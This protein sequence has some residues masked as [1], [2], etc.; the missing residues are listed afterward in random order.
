MD[1]TNNMN[2]WG[3]SGG[4]VDAPQFKAALANL[5]DGW[6]HVVAPLRAETACTNLGDIR[7]YWA[8]ASKMIG[9]TIILDDIRFVNQA[10]L[11]GAYADRTAAKDATIAIKAIPALDAITV[12]DQA[13]VTAAAE[14]FAAVKDE[15]KPL[16]QNVEAIAAAQAKI[17]ELNTPVVTYT[18][19]GDSF[20][21]DGE[22]VQAYQVIDF[23]GCVYFVSDYNKVA[24]N[25]TL[26]LGEKFI[27]EPGYYT[28]DAQGRAVDFSGVRDGYVFIHNVMQKAYQVVT[29]NGAQYFINDGNKV[30]TNCTLYLTAAFVETPGYYSFDA[31]GKMSAA[32][33]I[34]NG[35]YYEN[36]T[37]ARLYELVEIDGVTYFVN[38]GYFVAKDCVLYLGERFAPGAAGWYTFD[39]TGAMVDYVA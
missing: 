16:V 1:D 6:N 31:E 11:N 36:G 33:G 28:F 20:Y 17:D 10:A 37:V 18:F 22:L 3:E 24:K 34:L 29:V 12:E 4:K 38:D 39:A 14:A 30:A 25:C 2:A 23:E 7:I 13:I 5:K 27:D 26:Y 8:G 19:D 32:T 35:K 21:E 15:Y 9:M